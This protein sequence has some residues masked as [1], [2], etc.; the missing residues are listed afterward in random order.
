[1]ALWI[2][3]RYAEADEE[4]SADLQPSSQVDELFSKDFSRAELDD[5]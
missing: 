3:A 5:W 1:M 2:R 4:W